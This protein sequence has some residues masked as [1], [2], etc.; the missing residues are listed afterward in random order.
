MGER[1]DILRKRYATE[2]RVSNAH[3]RH[4]LQMQAL[5]AIR[6]MGIDVAIAGEPRQLNQ[7]LHQ[8]LGD[9]KIQARDKQL[10][11]EV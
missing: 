3:Q 5:V 9:V 1:I 8:L 2:K 11:I 4:N 7:L 10:Y 6:E